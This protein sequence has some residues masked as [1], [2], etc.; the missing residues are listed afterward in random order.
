MQAKYLGNNVTIINIEDDS[1]LITYGGNDRT[2]VKT[3]DLDMTLPKPTPE[4][5]Q[6]PAPE[7]TAQKPPETS[8]KKS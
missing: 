8:T 7:P 2:F 1:A 5:K 4:P 3:S 6:E